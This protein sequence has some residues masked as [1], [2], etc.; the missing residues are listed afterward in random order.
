MTPCMNHPHAQAAAQ[1]GGCGRPFCESCL[2]E[3]LGKRFCGPCRDFHLA[4]VRSRP[5]SQQPPNETPYLVVGLIF[6]ILALLATVG[7]V[8]LLFSS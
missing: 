6:L 1:C 2:V 8:L 3:F 7:G 4:H 5:R